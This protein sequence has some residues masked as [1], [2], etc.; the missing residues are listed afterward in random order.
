MTPTG[1]KT[2]GIPY[3]F[4]GKDIIICL[5]VSKRSR[6]LGVIVEAGKLRRRK[7]VRAG[8]KFVVPNF[9]MSFS[10]VRFLCGG[11]FAIEYGTLFK[12]NLARALPS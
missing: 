1:F 12:F 6:E 10:A 8:R 5:Y 3:S 9:S 11:D 4:L 7:V 2:R